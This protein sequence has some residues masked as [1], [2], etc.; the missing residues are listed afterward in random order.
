MTCQKYI[1]EGVVQ[2][3]SRAKEVRT[4]CVQAAF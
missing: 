3:L 4:L 2:V 1:I